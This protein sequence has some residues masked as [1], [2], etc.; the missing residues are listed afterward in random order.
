MIRAF[1]LALVALLLAGGGCTFERRPAAGE[2]AEEGDTTTSA[3][4][5]E[6]TGVG[7]AASQRVDEG[8]AFLDEFQEARETGR[9][10]EVRSRLHPRA[11]LILGSR[12]LSRQ[13]SGRDV[14]ALLDAPADEGAP[15]RVEQ[16]AEVGP[17]ILVVL[18]Y[19][20]TGA[21]GGGAVETLLLVPDSGGWSVRLLQRSVEPPS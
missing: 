7:L 6:P 10:S 16:V 1:H 12:R 8:R 21:T 20:G 18:A 15:G 14:R 4:N 11:L 3:G 19:P 2:A 9:L 17:G 5:A 13:G